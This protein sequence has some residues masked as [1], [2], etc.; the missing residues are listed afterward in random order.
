MKFLSTILCLF[1]LSLGTFQAQGQKIPIVPKPD[2]VKTYTA[3]LAWE[4]TQKE[5]TGAYYYLLSDKQIN[6]PLETRYFQFATKILNTEGIQEQSDISILYDPNFQKLHLHELSVYRAGKK[7]NKLKDHEIRV[8]QRERGNERFLYDGSLEAVV[9]L[10]DIRVGDIIVYSYSRMG[11]N[12][13]YDGHASSELYLDFTVPILELKTRLISREDRP[14]SFTYSGKKQ[15]PIIN[16]IKGGKEY[17]WSESQVDA[18]LY[19]KNVPKWFDPYRRVGYSD[20]TSWKEVVD[21][22]APLYQ[23]NEPSLT[24][25]KPKLAQIFTDNE[26]AVVLNQAIR[27]VQ[28]DIRYLGF[29][30]GINAFKP[31]PAE[32]VLDQRFGDCKDKSFLLCAILNAYDIEAYPV[33]VNT[34][35]QEHISAELPGLG[36]F[37]HCVAQINFEDRTFYIDPTIN[38]QGGKASSIHFPDYGKG[39]VIKEG[40]TQLTSIS[41]STRRETQIFQQLIIPNSRDSVTFLSKSIYYDAEA[42]RKRSYFAT[43]SLEEINKGYLDYYSAEYPGIVSTQQIKTTDNRDSSNQFIVEEF[44]LVP[45]TSQTSKEKSQQIDFEFYPLDFEGF[46]FHPKSAARTMPYATP[47]HADYSYNIRLCF[48][49]T[50]SGYEGRKSF[51]N[52]AYRYDFQ[53]VIIDDTISITYEYKTYKDHIQKDKVDDF[54]EEHQEMREYYLSY[55]ATYNPSK[56]LQIT[57]SQTG[58]LILIALML[59]GAMLSYK[60]YYAYDIMPTY[61]LR[62]DRPIKGMLWLMGGTL[63]LIPLLWLFSLPLEGHYL[64]A[65][66]W[67]IL[68]ITPHIHAGK[69]KALLGFQMIYEG[70]RV[71]CV[72]MLLVTFL[73]KRTVFPKLVLPFLYVNTVY[74]ILTPLIMSLWV[75]DFLDL[76]PS[77]GNTLLLLVLS[78]I[79]I[80]YLRNSNSIDQTFIHTLKA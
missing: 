69:I 60:L 26:P 63:G 31:H 76:V 11:F 40:N 35:K 27:F 64:N 45:N 34:E 62:R 4:N 54:L 43:T 13:V 39:L 46:L 10:R 55:T 42:D 73:K 79:S 24:S 66:V 74:T 71:G 53:S 65:Y 77:A 23:V 59:L 78:V 12:P 16:E 1:I 25:L 49:G 17:L 72:A 70:L 58:A 9:N 18:F 75:K 41:K 51:I 20:Y 28:D 61:A 57:L 22:V 8:L 36:V 67:D 29:E 50:A 38:Y 56:R 48:P 52:E 44:Y 3:D 7:I 33:L 37:D 68:D 15:T 21:D 6:I 19:D 80:L 32:Q 30:D 14:L 5:I 47:L 2:W